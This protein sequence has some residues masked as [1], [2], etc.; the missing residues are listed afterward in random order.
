MLASSSTY[1]RACY[2]SYQQPLPP[3]CEV[4]SSANIGW[5]SHYNASCPFFA[6]VCLQGA[7]SALR[8]DTGLIDVAAFGINA[9][10]KDRVGLRKVS[11]CA[12]APPGRYI[13]V[14]NMVKEPGV[15]LN[16]LPGE[17]RINFDFGKSYLG[18]SS[19]WSLSSYTFNR[20][21]Q[22]SMV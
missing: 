17:Q 9:P 21:R 22:Y 2:G 5:S 20:T 14:V 1:S 8:L 3:Q 4:Y 7:N 15:V 6:D 13:S 18:Y 10:R 19:T 11:T 16:P 12:V